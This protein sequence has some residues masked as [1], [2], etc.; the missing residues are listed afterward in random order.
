MKKA[1]AS[2]NLVL[3]GPLPDEMRAKLQIEIEYYEETVMWGVDEV[4]G[5]RV[6]DVVPE[7]GTHLVDL[8]TT[9]TSGHVVCP[10]HAF[11][12][13]ELQ[14][15]GYEVEWVFPE[16]ERFPELAE[17]GKRIIMRSGT[18]EDALT[19]LL[20]YQG[21]FLMLAP[22]KGK[23]VIALKA[24]AAFQERTL[25]FVDNGGLLT[26]WQE[27]IKEFWGMPEEEIGILQG[28]ADRWNWEDPVISVA[29]FSSFHLQH[30]AGAIPPHFFDHFGTVIWDEAQ[31]AKSETRAPTLS[32]FPSRR[33]GLSATPGRD[34]TQDMLFAHIGRPRVVD[35]KSDL[36]P[37]CHFIRVKPETAMNYPAFG[38]G[39]MVYTQMLSDCLGNAKKDPDPAYYATIVELIEKLREE[40]RK[41]IAIIGRAK[42]GR[43]L[44]D[45]L[46][47][48]VFI[49]QDVG[50]RVRDRELNRTDIVGVTPQIGERALDRKSLD[51]L[52]MCFPVGRKAIDRAQ[53]AAGRVLR[54]AEDKKQP[55]VYVLYPDIGAGRS[56]AAANEKLFEE[57]GYEIAEPASKAYEPGGGRRKRRI[58]KPAPRRIR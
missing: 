41:I 35:L 1:V 25:V 24:A 6:R 16:R 30:Q 22:G 21:G 43:M 48:M 34:G 10:R 19:S 29:M 12:E 40:D 2:R 51:T 31:L 58:A 39:Q 49:N 57:L 3:P 50:F 17:V 38:G 7:Q 4:T 46:E 37:Q 11:S 42:T 53:Q 5:R 14:K 54:A 32:M 23:T 27:R 28:P 56:L 33:I 15:W 9:L 52:I 36:N 18:Q 55:K 13:D 44:E 47:G 20:F 45:D 26:Q 8:S